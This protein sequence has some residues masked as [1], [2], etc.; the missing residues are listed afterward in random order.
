MYCLQFCFLIIVTV[1]TFCYV[2][3]AVGII[4]VTLNSTQDQNCTN[5]LRGC[6]TLSGR[7]E[8]S[9]MNG[10][11][12]DSCNE[13]CV[14]NCLRCNRTSGEC[15]RCKDGFYG[16]RCQSNCS[17]TCRY[18]C[19]Q[20]GVC[21]GCLDEYFGPQCQYKCS[22]NCS[23]G[24]ER[25]TGSCAYGC[26][27]GL[28]GDFCNN[29]CPVNCGSS[30]CHQRRGSCWTCKSGYGGNQC[31]TKCTDEH[32]SLCTYDIT[33]CSK[34]LDGWYGKHCEKNCPTSHC[35]TQSCDKKSGKCG[36]CESGWFGEYC[37]NKCIKNCDRCSDTTTC[38]VCK[39]G[40]YGYSCQLSCP[41]KCKNC[42]RD[43]E[44]KTCIDGF[45]GRDCMCEVSEC[46]NVTNNKCTQCKNETSWFLFE[47]A[48]CPCSEHCNQTSDQ[49]ICHAENGNCINGCQDDY[50]GDQCF[51]TCSENC[52]KGNQTTCNSTT[53]TCQNGCLPGWFMSKCDFNCSYNFPHCLE[54]KEYNYSPVDHFVL[55]Y[56]CGP[57]YYRDFLS[58]FCKPC[59]NCLNDSCDGVTGLCTY[60][61]QDGWYSLSGVHY[62]CQFRCS[63]NCLEQKCNSSGGQCLDGCNHGYY[64]S[65]CQVSCPRNCKNNTCYWETGNCTLGCTPGTYGYHCFL[66][67]SSRC[68]DLGCDKETGRCLECKPG[69]YGEKCEKECPGCLLGDCDRTSGECR[70]H[71]CQPKLYGPYCNT[72]CVDS[73]LICDEQSGHCSQCVTNRTGSKCEKTCGERCLHGNCVHGACANGCMSGYFGKLCSEACNSTC[74]A[75]VCDFKSGI[76]TDGCVSG[77]DGA[78]CEV[79]MAAKSRAGES[80]K[81]KYSTGELILIVLGSIAGVIIIVVLSCLLHSHRRNI[82]M[83]CYTR[84]EEA[85]SKLFAKY[86]AIVSKYPWPVLICSISANL[87]LGVG[88]LRLQSEGST[89]VLY[90]PLNSQA[91]IDR[92]RARSLFEMNYRENFDPL[93]Q[94]EV[95]SP[96]EILFRTKLG[97]NILQKRYIDEIKDIDNFIQNSIS[98]M[99]NVTLIDVCAKSKGSCLVSGE[100]IITET[101]LTA[102]NKGRVSFP[103]YERSDISRRLGEVRHVNRTLLSA[104]LVR[105]QY[106][107][108]Y[109]NETAKLWEREF[110]S[111]MKT[112]ESSIL[113]IAISTSQSLDI[114]LDNNVSGDILWISLTF[115]IML[116]YASLATTGTRINC[117]ADRSNLGRAGVLATVLAILGSFGLTSAAGVEYVSLV[118]VMPFLIVGIGLD[119]VF[120]LLSGLA[121]APLTGSDGTPTTIQQRISFAMA[122]S[123]VSI[124]I[125][126]LTDFLAFGIGS[127]SSFVS[128]RNFSIYTGVAVCFCYINQLTLFVPCMVI[129]ERRADKSRHAFT[130]LKTKSKE[131]L[132]EEGRSTLYQCCCAGR[133]ADTPEDY[134]NFIQKYPTKFCQFL[135]G[136]FVGKIFILLVFITYLGFSIYGCLNLKQGLELQNLV[137]EKSY[138]YKFNVWNKQY[139]DDVTPVSFN[140]DKTLNYHTQ[141]VQNEMASYIKKVKDNVYISPH[142]DRFWLDVYSQSSLFNNS[143]KTSFINGLKQFMQYRPDLSNDVAFDSSETSIIA[144]RFHVMSEPMLSTTDS[145]NLMQNVRELASECKFSVF[146]YTPG[147]IFYEQYVEIFPATMQTLGIAVAVMMVVTTIFMPN[148]FLVVIVTVTLV[149]ILLGIVGFMHFLDLTLSSITMIDL[150][151]TVGFSVDFSAHICHAYMSVS[152]NTRKEKVHQALSRSGGP[153]FNSAFSSILG[154]L[155]LI[156]SKSYI[157]L[158]F[159][160]LMLIVMIFGLFHALWVLPLFLSIIGP[161]MHSESGNDEEKSKDDKVKIKL[162]EKNNLPLKQVEEGSKEDKE[163]GM[164]PP[165]EQPT[166]SEKASSEKGF[167]IETKVN[168]TTGDLENTGN[169][170]VSISIKL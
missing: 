134:S 22:T 60:G 78:F 47:D 145:G 167:D 50:I 151:M 37:E 100:Q 126:S 16:G 79:N 8:G 5:C 14:P 96:T 85:V 166:E 150:I 27:N 117:I 10:F 138:L 67:C 109:N 89:E 147:F 129:N 38:D 169:N 75:D 93:A 101:F 125:T 118:G 113:D 43:G 132:K 54:C 83:G 154:I 121:D 18:D 162:D 12:G 55:C 65:Y 122:T 107:L 44:C 114:E 64:S 62:Q 87:L 26:V 116:T 168:D 97:E 76:C 170:V 34:C 94:I 17:S 25:D 3:S 143:S 136:N 111:K 48:C 161:M 120:I 160:K 156:F 110:I 52:L 9:C 140:F 6:N 112:Y 80:N 42:E 68:S 165:D 130:C 92:D 31:S 15:E 66:P 71:K 81:S 24:C 144:S 51:D 39:A 104:G 98:V 41:T 46:S 105:L 35:R 88:L 69:R 19:D 49:G 91:S 142:F 36:S 133:P 72:S 13:T 73:C 164:S 148:I 108:L 82:N 103:V 33:S 58:G 86:G 95:N 115:T 155:M 59:Y 53:G 23:L 74:K 152:G 4:S 40:F 124:S 102:F 137:S 20:E 123:G 77:W 84:Y 153:I 149:I 141:E 146:A 163:L 30:S 135:V 45:K 127:S 159:F 157:F 63:E 158:S 32:C 70:Q 106:S 11:F 7:C 57:G 128:I 28:W 90:T 56:R 61:C 2:S 131:E 1:V 21:F 139:F 119:D 29:S 99:S